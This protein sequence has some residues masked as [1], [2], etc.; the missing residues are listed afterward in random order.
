MSESA[1][2]SSTSTKTSKASTAAGSDQ[3]RHALDDATEQGYFGEVED[4]PDETLQ[5]VIAAAKEK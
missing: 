4:G 3:V 2:S 5:G 1:S